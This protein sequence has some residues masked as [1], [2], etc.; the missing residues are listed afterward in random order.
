ML[1]VNRTGHIRLATLAMNCLP[2]R[3]QVN[4]FI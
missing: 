2:T 1:W 4:R 3:S